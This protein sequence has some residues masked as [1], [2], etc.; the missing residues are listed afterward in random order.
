MAKTFFV[1]G[2]NAR[3]VEEY[4]KIEDCLGV[5]R[6]YLN[7]HP[8]AYGQEIFISSGALCYQD[9]LDMPIEGLQTILFGL[10]AENELLSEIMVMAN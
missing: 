7:N 8:E 4:E 1:A 2:E 3:R 10:Q 6:T 5:I 9:L